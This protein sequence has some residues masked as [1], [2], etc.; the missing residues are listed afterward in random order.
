MCDARNWFCWIFL[1][2]LI[3]KFGCFV[4]NLKLPFQDLRVIMD[5]FFFLFRTLLIMW[6]AIKIN[7]QSEEIHFQLC[8]KIWI[9]KCKLSSIKMSKADGFHTQNYPITLSLHSFFSQN[10]IDCQNG[11]LDITLLNILMWPDEYILLQ[12]AQFLWRRVTSFSCDS[13][14]DKES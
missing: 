1:S 3:I 4:L 10:A 13:F 7:C 6:I 5:F 14:D 12:V 9:V 8:Q 2:T 11:N